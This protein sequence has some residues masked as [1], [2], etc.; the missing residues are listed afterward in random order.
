MKK[1]RLII[2]IKKVLELR[3]HGLDPG[4]TTWLLHDLF[5]QVT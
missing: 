5:E 3:D 1:T 2:T 4:P